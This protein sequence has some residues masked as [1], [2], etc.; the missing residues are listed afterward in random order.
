MAPALRAAPVSTAGAELQGIRSIV[1]GK[2]TWAG[3]DR[4]REC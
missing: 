3:T 1:L 4:P 2:K